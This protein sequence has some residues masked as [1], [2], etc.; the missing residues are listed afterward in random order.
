V[1]PETPAIRKLKHMDHHAVEIEVLPHAAGSS[2]V[3]RARLRSNDAS[4]AAVVVYRARSG[5]VGLVVELP[6]R[7]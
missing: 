1:K 7:A 4:A 5:E 3:R 2:G 6:G